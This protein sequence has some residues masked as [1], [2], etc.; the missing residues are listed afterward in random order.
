MG[1]IKS[2]QLKM[3]PRWYFILGSILSVMG[4]AGLTVASIFLTGL[5]S[6]SLRSHGPMGALRLDQL[7]SNFPWWAVALAAVGIGAGVWMLKQN[8]FSYKKNFPL[9]VLGFILAIIIAGWL[10]DQAGI[11]DTLRKRGPMPMRRFY[12]Q[13]NMRGSFISPPLIANPRGC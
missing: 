5:A 2:G 1:Q 8:D 7:I 4:L 9:I 11:N 3:K 10:I 12:Q 13:Q 6:F